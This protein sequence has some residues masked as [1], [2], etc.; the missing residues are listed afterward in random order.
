LIRS[1][2]AI[3]LPAS[4]QKSIETVQGDLKTSRADVRWVH[5]ARI[6]LTLKFFGE[7]EEAAV[8]GILKAIEGPL[9]AVE[10]FSLTARG[11]G[12]FPSLRNP[13]VVWMGM[14]GEEETLLSLQKGLE[15]ELDRIGFSPEGRPFRPHLTLGRVN[16]DRGRAALAERMERYRDEVF[17]T[18]TVERVVL[19]KS[20]LRPT[21][22]VYSPLG[23]R[24]VGGRG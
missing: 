9:G 24:G 17:G 20:E 13:R 10:P 4:I 11:T 18:F 5:P 12:A 1:F 19:F 16:S 2:L 7:I 21:G 15:T 23:E 3:E 14:A 6:H 8:P 22:P